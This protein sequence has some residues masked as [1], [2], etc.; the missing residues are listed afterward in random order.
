MPRGRGRGRVGRPPRGRGRG[1]SLPTAR[2]SVSVHTA[3]TPL[4]TSLPVPPTR[5]RGAAAHVDAYEDEAEQVSTATVARRGRGGSGRGHRGGGGGRGRGSWRGRQSSSYLSGHP[6]IES[7]TDRGGGV[8]AGPEMSSG[9]PYGTTMNG[10]AP[11]SVSSPVTTVTVLEV[12]RRRMITRALLNGTSPAIDEYAALANGGEADAGQTSPKPRGRPGPGR[13]S[14]DFSPAG[15]MTVGAQ[16]AG[17][18]TMASFAPFG[19]GVSSPTDGTRRIVVGGVLRCVCNAFLV[20]PSES[21]LE[22][23][24]CRNWCHPACVGVDHVELKMY[25]RQR[26]YVC[27]YCVAATAT[28]SEGAFSGASMSVTDP[29]ALLLR[30]LSEVYA[31][32]TSDTAYTA[33]AALRNGESLE[34]NRGSPNPLRASPA[35][36]TL[37]GG[38]RGGRGRGGLREE[39]AEAPLHTSPISSLHSS[40]EVYRGGGAQPLPSSTMALTSAATNAM[41]AAPILTSDTFF[42]GHRPPAPRQKPL[43]LREVPDHLPSSGSLVEQAR[44][45]LRQVHELANRLGYDVVDMPSK[46]DL[47]PVELQQCLECCAEAVRD[48]TFSESYPLYCLKEVRSHLH[49]YVQGTYLRCRSANRI[50]SLTL[51]NGMDV[52]GN[53]KPTITQLKSAVR[54]GLMEASSFTDHMT[55]CAAVSD[56]SDFVHIT[57]SATHVEYQRRGLA[58]LLMVSELLKWAL[59]GRTRA[60]LNMAIEKRL[61][62]GGARV[63]YGASPASR[64]LY[65]SFG[66]ADVHPRFDAETQK[67]R[68]TA[69]EADMGRV[70][71]NLDFIPH[72]IT[73]AETLGSRYSV[74][75][76]PLPSSVAA[77]PA[78]TTTT[79][80]TLSPLSRSPLRRPLPSPHTFDPLAPAPRTASSSRSPARSTTTTSTT[81]TTVTTVATGVTAGQVDVDIAEDETSTS[82][83]VIAVTVP[84][85]TGRGGGRSPLIVGGRGGRGGAAGSGGGAR[86]PQLHSLGPSSAGTSP[87]ESVL[88]A[89]RRGLSPETGTSPPLPPAKR[90][91]LALQK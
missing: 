83:S 40:Q 41:V 79:A 81:A 82:S 60:Y 42:V 31:A 28:A 18:P 1:A 11:G 3:T 78:A 86:S 53:L 24:R 61:V 89:R 17:S 13:G 22:C 35:P 14:S 38:G 67:E 39:K 80:Q 55:Q 72:V 50:C 30:P 34:G 77:S 33:T 27:P 56:V 29:T 76:L 66:F 65:E 10:T 70:M 90:R 63:E 54:R 75:T 73:I 57:L 12:P 88:S 71:A 36:S 87:S 9:Y 6:S 51:S 64:R 16:R 47:T 62:D 8:Q 32:S 74:P 21:L 19:G 15:G 46:T 37:P 2:E 59:R 5:P 85:P 7:N 45:L 44:T 23:S 48:A 58:R 52:Y 91:R 20:A 69:K 25:L 49:Q 26:T 4:S 68:W 43:K 84:A